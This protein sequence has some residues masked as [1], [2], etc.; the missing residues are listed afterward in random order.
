[1]THFLAID[2]HDPILPGTQ[3]LVLPAQE[4]P[5]HLV[6]VDR[7]QHAGKGRLSRTTQVTVVGIRAKLQSPQFHARALDQFANPIQVATA[8][9]RP[10]YTK[11]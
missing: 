9:Q 1:V 4:R 7:M 2:D 3:N 10:R 5:F 8:S 6:I 11:A